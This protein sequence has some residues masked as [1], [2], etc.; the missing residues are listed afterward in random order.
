LFQGGYVLSKNNV[1][2]IVKIILIAIILIWSLFP[3]YW[4]VSIAIRGNKEL[5]GVLSII[6]KSFSLEHIKNLF[7]KEDFG[8]DVQNSFYIT[9]ISLTISLI[10]GTACAYILAGSRFKFK[11][12]VP[13]LVWI[14]I[15]RVVPPITLALPLYS[16]MNTLGLLNTKIPIIS[17]HVLVNLPFIIWFMITFFRAIPQELS[18][19]AKIDG[20]NEMTLYIKIILR[21]VAPGLVA[22]AIFSFMNSWNEYLYSM[23]F[24]QNPGDFT[25]PLKLAT[26][27]SEQELTQWG[28]VASGGIISLLPVMIFTIF[29]QKYLIKGLASGAVKE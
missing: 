25:I 21:L 8:L 10:L 3:I 18:E 14:L 6:P 16:L 20:A 17:A 28:K 9:A 1:Y 19:S 2:K 22:V 7:V 12:K 24:I 5:S 15:I 23:I 4:M 27:N 26:F 11:L 13:L 29:M